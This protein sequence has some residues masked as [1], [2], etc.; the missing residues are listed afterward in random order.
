VGV[1]ARP[2]PVV[3]LSTWQ[4]LLQ[5][6]PIPRLLGRG[7]HSCLLWLACLLTVRVKE[8]PSP[9]HWSSGCPALFAI[10]LFFSC[11]FI[12]QFGFFFSFFPGWRSVCPGGYGDLFQGEPHATYLLTWWSPKDVRSWHL[13]AQEPSQFLC[14][15][16][17]GDA[18]GGLRVWGCRSFASSWW[19]FLTGVS[20]IISSRVYF[21]KHA[22][23]FLPLVTILESPVVQLFNFM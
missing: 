6:S 20:P 16:W 13:A 11:L 22:F 5:A 7:C 12:I 10:C 18:M 2:C 15:T 3:G 21:R 9:I 19:F 1:S 8:C 23:C 4:P 14:L 17:H